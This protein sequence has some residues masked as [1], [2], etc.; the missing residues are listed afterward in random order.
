MKNRY[1]TSLLVLFVGVDL[2]FTFWQNYH[3]PLDG[4]LVAV[5]LPA[6][7]YTPVLHDPFGWSVLIKNAVY[8]APNRFFAHIKMLVYWQNVPRLLQHVVD[9]ISS[10]YAASAL[11]TTLTQAGLLFLLAKY[12]QTVSGETRGSFWVI[13][14]LLTPFFQTAGG[15]YEQMG[16]TDRAVT[17]TFFYALAMLL[18]L[19]LLWPFYRA[20]S[21]QQPLRLPW[22]RA[23]LLVA[24]MVV[25]AFD[26]PI[27]TA[28]LAV[29]LLGIGG[30]WAWG[31]ARRGRLS[32]TRPALGQEWLSGQALLLLGTLAGLC[33]YS[34]Y[35]GRNNIENTRTYSL[36]QLYALLPIGALRYLTY[37]PG[38]PLLLLA[39]AANVLLLRRGV[40]PSPARHR[41]LRALSCVGL[42][43]GVYLLLLPLGGYRS[44]RPALL[45]N[46]TA[47]PML[48]GLLFSYGLSTSFLLA[49]LRGRWRGSYAGAVCL[50]GA[51]FLYADAR[52]NPGITNDCERWSLDQLARAKEPVVELTNTCYVLAWTPITDYYQSDIQ[53]QMLYYW[54]VTPDKKLYFQKP[55]GQ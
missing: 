28:A 37:Q 34:L 52:L 27:A 29:L 26:G 45:R 16:I 13:A 3:L 8:G 44:Y 18:V 4:D 21:R 35:I 48:L 22:P 14:A 9:P 10:L 15:F 39:L 49:R 32:L 46:D 55:V 40:A 6:S 11:F 25:V 47:L 23:L 43:A 24:L 31:Q 33:L 1:L 7:W 38:V 50:L 42:F 54:G 51:F 53:G 5:V 19:V 20:A 17:Y 41:V 36:Q 12:I 2:L 30:Y